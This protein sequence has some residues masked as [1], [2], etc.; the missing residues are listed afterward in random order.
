MT[1]V[2]AV[3]AFIIGEAEKERKEA[4]LDRKCI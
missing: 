1:G 2:V 4:N 3:Y